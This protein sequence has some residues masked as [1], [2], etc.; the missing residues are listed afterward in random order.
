VK[1][2]HAIFSSVPCLAVWYFFILS[3]K[4]HENLFLSTNVFWFPLQILSETFFHSR[5]SCERY[6]HIGLHA[7]YILLLSNLTKLKFSRP[8]FQKI[9]K[10]QISWKFVK[11]ELSY[12]MR[13]ERRTDMK[14]IIVAFRS[15]AEA[16]RRE[17][18]FH[19]IPNCIYQNLRHFAWH[20]IME[21]ELCGSVGDI[22]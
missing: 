20:R 2:T 10:Y 11:W 4:R 9:V 7:K 6:K 12:S 18:N 13:A 22:C 8:I 14:Q 5:N 21:A 1:C 19:T 17:P 16:P 3:H 15:F